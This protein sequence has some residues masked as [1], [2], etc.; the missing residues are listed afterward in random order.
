MLDIG[1]LLALSL[2][3]FGDSF[4][5]AAYVLQGRNIIRYLE[6][7]HPVIYPA[8]LRCYVAQGVFGGLRELQDRRMV[9]SALVL[10]AC[11]YD[12]TLNLREYF[13]RA[14]TTAGLAAVE[15]H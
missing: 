4:L 7:R 13:Y 11:M 15:T 12:R 14:D 2:T 1:E 9:C 10:L 3:G 5:F 8:F 6:Y